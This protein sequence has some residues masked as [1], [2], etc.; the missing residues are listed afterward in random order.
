MLT[1][2]IFIQ[3]AS[4][5]SH[6]D[7]RSCGKLKNFAEKGMDECGTRAEHRNV[8]YCNAGPLRGFYEY[9]GVISTSWNIT[10]LLLP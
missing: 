3:R 10:L 1:Q 7:L 8:T 6:A 5:W 2:G 4:S 9:Q